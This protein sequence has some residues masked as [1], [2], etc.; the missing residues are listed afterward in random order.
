MDSGHEADLRRRRVLPDTEQYLHR[1]LVEPLVP[2]ALRGERGAVELLREQS[3]GPALLKLADGVAVAVELCDFGEQ[4]FYLGVRVP[5]RGLVLEDKVSTHAAAREL[6]HAFV[7][8]RSVRVRVEV[9]R[10]RVANVFE[11]LHE[12][13]GRLRVRG[14]EAQVLIVSARNLIV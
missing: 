5:A 11:E 9:A 7:V 12:P 13:E 14:A 10:P 2:Q 4:G 6:L 1:E 8:L 3:V